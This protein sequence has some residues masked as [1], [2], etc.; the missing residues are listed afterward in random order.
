M[1]ARINAPVLKV[2]GA[3]CA[4]L[5]LAGGTTAAIAEPKDLPTPTAA[6]QGAC[7]YVRKPDHLKALKANGVKQ[8]DCQQQLVTAPPSVFSIVDAIKQKAGVAGDVPMAT[9]PQPT[10]S[11]QMQANGLAP[12]SDS[13]VPPLS[14]ACIGI[15]QLGLRTTS[16]MNACELYAFVH[17]IVRTSDG[18]ILGTAWFSVMTWQDLNPRS[19][20]W[21][22]G[23]VIRMESAV[24]AAVPGIWTY[25][26]DSCGSPCT[27]VSDNPANDWELLHQGELW[28][29]STTLKSVSGVIDRSHTASSIWTFS[30]ITNAQNLAMGVTDN[31]PEARC[32]RVDYLASN[33]G[34]GCVYGDVTGAL[35]ESI[36]NPAVTQAAQFMRDA[37]NN[38]PPHPGLRGWQPL[39]RASDYEAAANRAISGPVCSK[40][41]KTSGQQCDEYP[42]AATQQGAAFGEQGFWWDVRAVNGAQNQKVGS[43]LSVMFSKERYFYGDKFW[44]DVQN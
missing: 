33:S 3:V 8:A 4:G 18:A 23:H 10:G 5:L 39:T 11:G 26:W 21:T 42:F 14:P 36:S 19:R 35:V 32:D 12:Y 43:D 25:M 2:V 27:K 31:Y 9:F 28:G 40:L 17:Y 37:Q 22:V 38:L 7:E 24:D 16:R 1:N 13:I 20:T 29:G 41:P 44:V 34:E 6:A 15:N 30:T